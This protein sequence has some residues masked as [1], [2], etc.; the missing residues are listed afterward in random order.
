MC[1]FG[2]A[3]FSIEF[4]RASDLLDLAQVVAG[5][6]LYV[7]NQSFGSALA[8]A[9]LIPRVAQL[10]EPSPNRMPPINGHRVLTREILGTYLD[11]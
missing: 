6:K 1:A 11:R 3:Y 4:Y 5:A 9:M 7:G 8:D 2:A 10:W